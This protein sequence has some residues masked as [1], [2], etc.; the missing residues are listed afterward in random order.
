MEV[1]TS[2][3]KTV[4]HGSLDLLAY[5]DAYAALAAMPDASL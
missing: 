5:D 3:Q 1:V 4:F 2:L